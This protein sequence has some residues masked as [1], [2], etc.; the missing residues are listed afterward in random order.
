MVTGKLDVR[1]AAARLPD[2]NPDPEP[3]DEEPCDGGQE[4]EEDDAPTEE[5][6]AG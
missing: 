1:E 2:E 6:D 4:R 5:V 3:A